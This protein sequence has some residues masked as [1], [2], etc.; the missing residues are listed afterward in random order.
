MTPDFKY[1]FPA[2]TAIGQSDIRHAISGPLS[3]DQPLLRIGE[4]ETD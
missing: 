1:A 2:G 3:A 4:T